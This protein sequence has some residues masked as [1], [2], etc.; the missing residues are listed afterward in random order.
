M[1]GVNGE[2]FGIVDLVGL[3]GG[4]GYRVKDLEMYFVTIGLMVG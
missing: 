1:I 2:V 3:G 4:G